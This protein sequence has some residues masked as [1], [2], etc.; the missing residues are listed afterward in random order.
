MEPSRQ[1]KARKEVEMAR[2]KEA[3]SS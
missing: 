3:S 1:E 2:A